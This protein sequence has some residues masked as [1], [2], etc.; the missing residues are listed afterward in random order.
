MYTLLVLR[1]NGA[2]LSISVDRDLLTTGHQT[3][4]LHAPRMTHRPT[5]FHSVWTELERS[6]G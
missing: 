4:V 2:S 6:Q 5:K 1:I 3:R